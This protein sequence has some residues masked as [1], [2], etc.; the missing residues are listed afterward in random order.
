MTPLSRRTFLRGTGVCLALPLLEAMLPA[1]I[2]A[3][4]SAAAAAATGS[5][6]RVVAINVP[7]GFIPE[8]ATK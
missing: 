5:P 3:A 1:R 4:G 7:L 2:R 8:K 6:Q